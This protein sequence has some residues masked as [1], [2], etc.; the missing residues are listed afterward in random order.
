M[1]TW[2]LMRSEWRDI[3]NRTIILTKT[4]VMIMEL[5]I[6]GGYNN[7][8]TIIIHLLKVTKYSVIRY[9]IEMTMHN[10]HYRTEFN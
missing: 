3:N 6:I 9:D 1:M 10:I 4:T 7:P 5:G 8:Q 2:T